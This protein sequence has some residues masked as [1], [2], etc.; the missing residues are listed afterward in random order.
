LLEQKEQ[1]GTNR[2]APGG[3]MTAVASKMED[4][5]IDIRE[6]IYVRAPRD[7]TFATLLEQL[8]PLNE[9]DTGRAMPMKLEAWPGG[10]WFRDLGEG[11]G[12]FWG[13]VQAIKRPTLLDICGPLLVHP[14]D[15]E[16][17]VSTEGRK[18]RHAAHLSPLGFWNHFGR[19]PK[20]ETGLGTYPCAD[21]QTRRSR[22]P[23]LIVP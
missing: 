15:V 4:L 14:G 19:V 2:P 11:N 21:G 13:S 6:E 1:G 9:V 10:R 18:R 5:T 23:A 17:A 7:V 22:P 3:K 16:F 8:G 12:H 20:R